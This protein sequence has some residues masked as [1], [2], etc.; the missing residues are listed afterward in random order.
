MREAEFRDWLSQRTYKGKPLKPSAIGSRLSWMRALERALPDL[1]FDEGNVDAVYAAGRWTELYQALGALMR[2]WR[3]NEAAARR[4]APK[5]GDPT[6]QL[7]N[8]NA[9]A[10]LYGYFA[11]GKEPSF[12]NEGSS[13]ASSSLR[14]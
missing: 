7:H 1:G 9:A 12:C 14:R 3:T 5:A 4:I 2:D 11:E 8:T 6:R 10:R 13:A